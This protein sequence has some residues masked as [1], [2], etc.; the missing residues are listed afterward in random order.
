[1]AEPTAD[2]LDV[3][4][5]RIDGLDDRISKLRGGQQQMVNDNPKLTPEEQRVA[6]AAAAE[7]AEDR[8]ALEILA[9]PGILSA[10]DADL[11]SRTTLRALRRCG[12][13]R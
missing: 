1:V 3:I 11:L 10:E 9:K 13:V 12:H 5:T 4:A 2:E 7:E 8:V 6:Q